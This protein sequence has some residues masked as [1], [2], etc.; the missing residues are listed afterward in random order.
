MILKRTWALTF[1]V[2]ITIW[3]AMVIGQIF[4]S[5][6]KKHIN[7]IAQKNISDFEYYI[8]IFTIIGPILD[9]ITIK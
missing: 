1:A 3:G 8:L 7:L 6:Y 4:L 9:M 5:Q 2:S